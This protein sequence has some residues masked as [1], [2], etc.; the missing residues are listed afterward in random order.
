VFYGDQRMSR[1]EALKSYTANG[2]FA[3][4]EENSKG[5][6][7]VGKYADMVILSK[8]ILTVAE[9]E[10]PTAQVLYTIVAGK[11]RFKR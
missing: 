9:D 7:K 1:L 3:A 5:S 2:A 4:F 6:I 11:V 8:D 10:V